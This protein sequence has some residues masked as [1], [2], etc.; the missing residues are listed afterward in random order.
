ML[1]DI[2]DK[3]LIGTVVLPTGDSQ[4]MEGPLEA[5]LKLLSLTD[6]NC[7]RSEIIVRYE[8]TKES[9]STLTHMR[10]FIVFGIGQP[11]PY[12]P[13]QRTSVC[14]QSKESNIHPIGPYSQED[15]GKH[16]HPYHVEIPPSKKSNPP[17]NTSTN[18]NGMNP[19]R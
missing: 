2:K 14:T 10:V 1:E 19:P 5:K 9:A 6:N 16:A 4:L 17:S 3:H 12:T 13:G 18:T 7:L 8:D 15:L 11:G